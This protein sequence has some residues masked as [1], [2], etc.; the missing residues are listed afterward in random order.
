M[1]GVGED[2]ADW[3]GFWLGRDFGGRRLF[4]LTMWILPVVSP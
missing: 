2:G 3:L 4:S 1:E